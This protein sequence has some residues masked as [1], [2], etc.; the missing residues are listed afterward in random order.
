MLA[1]ALR[2]WPAQSGSS[3]RSLASVREE[4]ER[5][6][7]RIQQLLEASDEAEGLRAARKTLDDTLAFGSIGRHQYSETIAEIDSAA[8]STG[9]AESFRTLSAL[10]RALEH[11]HI[12]RVEAAV[13]LGR[14]LATDPALSSAEPANMIEAT[15]DLMVDALRRIRSVNRASGARIGATSIRQLQTAAKRSKRA[16]SELVTVPDALKRAGELRAARAV[17]SPSRRKR[18]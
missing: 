6:E 14:L 12:S 16:T 3:R 1:R 8:Q 13:S 18:A 11:A 5:A 2:L 9:S 15:D 17:G 4:M 7:R 10:V